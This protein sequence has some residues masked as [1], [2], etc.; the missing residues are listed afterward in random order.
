M[1]KLALLAAAG[2]A[3]AGCKRNTDAKPSSLEGSAM[4]PASGAGSGGSA[5]ATMPKPITQD[6]IAKRF[7]D[8]WKQWGIA[9]WDAVQDCYTSDAS[10]DTPG[11]GMPGVTGN[12]SIVALMQSRRTA[13]SDEKGQTQLVLVDGRKL[14]GITLLT[15]K[16][17]G[18]MKT[19]MGESPATGKSIG[20][21]M[22]Q[23]LRFDDKGKI[24]NESDYL[25]HATLE[26]QLEPDNGHPSRSAIEKLTIPAQTVVAKDDAAEK[27]NLGIAKQFVDGFNKH[28]DKALAGL[29]ADDAV[30]SD[31]TQPKNMTKKQ[32][33]SHLG[34]LWKGFSD[35]KIAGADSMAAGNYVTTTASFEGTN[36]GDLPVMHVKKTGKKVSV[37]VL[38]VHEFAGGKV[39]AAWLFY[40]S[41]SLASQL[42][43]TA[44]ASKK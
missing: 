15:G 29:I 44:T 23:V 13:F 27:A 17:T 40:Q 7:D 28:D 21:Y 16:N 20:L 32:L 8:C 5:T 33:I 37:P 39:K 36:D 42:G 18:P 2:L 12:A 6:E 38:I 9:K 25:D 22:G 30:W 11:S 43:M 1:N 19:P 14:V 10:F 4:T 3:L 26:H 31:R 35:L 24:T 34:L 41:T